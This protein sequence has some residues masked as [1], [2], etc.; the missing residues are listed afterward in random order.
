MTVQSDVTQIIKPEADSQ[1]KL[2]PCPECE[3]DDVAYE[4]YQDGDRELWRVRCF[5]CGHC[6]DGKTD[7]RHD[8]QQLWNE[9]ARA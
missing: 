5:G 7:V 1:Y 8:A 6:V 4:A 3:S 2:L 9:E